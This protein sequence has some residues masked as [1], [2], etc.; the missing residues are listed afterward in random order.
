MYSHLK[1]ASKYDRF[2]LS[3]DHLPYPS[4]SVNSYELF[5]LRYKHET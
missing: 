2:S 3:S 1:E 4:C 5:I